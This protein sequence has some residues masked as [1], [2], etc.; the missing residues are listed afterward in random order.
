MRQRHP[1]A[2][3]AEAKQQPGGW[4]YELRGVVDVDGEVPPSD[5]RGAWKVDD[6]GE[7][8]GDF[9]SNPNFDPNA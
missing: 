7:I 2:L 1:D 6:R 5:I 8:V 9:V 4:V 3:L